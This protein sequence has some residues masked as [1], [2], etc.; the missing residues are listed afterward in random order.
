MCINI[1]SLTETDKNKTLH[2]IF[3]ITSQ[4]P[5]HSIETTM[6]R[7]RNIKIDCHSLAEN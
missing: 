3:H 2:M 1:P 4:L 7:L 5:T 6:M